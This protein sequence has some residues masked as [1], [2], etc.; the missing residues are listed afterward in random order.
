[1]APISLLR[2][3]RL[4]PAARPALLALVLGSMACA[5]GNRP[6]P[7]DATGDPELQAALRAARPE[8]PRQREALEAGLYE[9]F[10][11]PE[12]V[13]P[14]VD[15]AVARA[16]PVGAAAVPSREERPSAAGA[17]DPSTE[18]LLRSLPSGPARKRAEPSPAEP[19]PA[20]PSPSGYTLQL[21]AFSEERAARVRAQEGLTAAPEL[22]VQVVREGGLVRVFLGR[23]ATRGEA[24][25]ALRSLAGSGL[26]PAWVTRLGR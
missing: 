3:A 19:S 4:R 24:E 16:D 2:S 7:E 11:P 13:P 20:E 23:F 10:V 8:F 5:H 6:P 25:S 22:S 17:E 12:S 26:G 18:E 21:G 1:M 15:G 9:T 14:P